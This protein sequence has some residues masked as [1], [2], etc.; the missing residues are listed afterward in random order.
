M[1]GQNLVSQ[2]YSLANQSNFNLLQLNP[3]V[4]GT[5]GSIPIILNSRV[6]GLNWVNA[7]G[8]MPHTES[9]TY[10]GKLIKEKSYYNNRGFLNRGKNAF[11]KVGLGFGVFNNSYGGIDQKGVHVD[12]SYQVYLATGRISFG[13]S[14]VFH[15]VNTRFLDNT[16]IFNEN[17]DDV[18]SSELDPVKLYFLDF[19]A[20][21]HYFSDNLQI[22]L[23][24]LLILNS[25]INLKSKYGI[26]NA[27]EPILNPD[28]SRTYIGYGGYKVFINRNL[29]IEPFAVAKYNGALRN[30]FEYDLSIRGY[31][32]DLLETGIFYCQ[33]RSVGTFL[34][35]LYGP[36]SFRY[37]FEYPVNQTKPVFFFSQSIQIGF[38][39]GHN[40]D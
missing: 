10:S 18:W 32:Y 11:S 6:T 8:L 30:K 39:P 9:F 35:I 31:L 4:A 25:K 28:M 22:G 21:M 20:G 2:I 36:L 24:S 38:N 17:P 15:I 29:A 19:N 1:N 33:R 14:P 5:P 34:G 16:L 26:P 7:E 3:A 23:A 40:L 37:Q 13:L 27:E 12:Y